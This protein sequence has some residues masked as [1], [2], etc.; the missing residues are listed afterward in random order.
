MEL[1]EMCDRV[2]DR[3]TF[4]RFV[5]ALLK[6]LEASEK[7]EKAHPSSPYGP[8]ARGW[9]NPDLGRFLWAM[10]RWT[11]DMGKKLPTEPR[12]QTF[13]AMLYMGKIYE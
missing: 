7:E 6:D 9:E 2:K 4:L 12:W 5:E 13:A 1:H 10:Q 8:T 3:K 11:D